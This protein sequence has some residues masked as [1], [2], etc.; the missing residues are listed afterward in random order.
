VENALKHAIGTRL[1]GGS[2]RIAAETANG[3]LRI[4]VADDGAGFPRRHREGTGLGNLRRRL[5]TI[6]GDRASLGIDGA[7][8]GGR[9]VVEIPAEGAP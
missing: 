1:Q 6:Y 7:A 2:L 4:S 8:R 9:V 5:R 3:T